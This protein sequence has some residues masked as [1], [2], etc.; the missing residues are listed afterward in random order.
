MLHVVTIQCVECPWSTEIEM[1]CLVMPVDDK[2]IT[3][4]NLSYHSTIEF[5]IL[6]G[7]KIA[8]FNFPSWESVQNAEHHTVL[9]QEGLFCNFYNQSHSRNA[10]VLQTFH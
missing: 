4:K 9:V 1:L 5:S 8:T 2:L 10:L 6:I 7:R 3:V